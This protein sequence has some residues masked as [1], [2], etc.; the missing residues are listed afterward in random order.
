MCLADIGR[1]N[2]NMLLLGADRN[3][4]HVFWHEFHQP[5]AAVKSPAG[6]IDQSVVGPDIEP[7]IRMLPEEFDEHGFQ[8]LLNSSCGGIDADR[9]RRPVAIPFQRIECPTDLTKCRLQGFRKALA[10]LGQR[11]VAGRANEEL[12]LEPSLQTR[13]RMAERRRTV[14]DCPGRCTKATILDH[15]KERGKLGGSEVRDCSIKLI[16]TYHIQRLHHTE[17]HRHLFSTQRKEK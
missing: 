7:H 2:D 11:H 13:N 8:N 6:D 5:E 17:R 4:H 12:N 3:G 15:G 1:G 14:A 16:M 10:R 9:P